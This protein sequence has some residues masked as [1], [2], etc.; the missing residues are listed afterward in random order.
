MLG[1]IN[2]AECICELIGC[3]RVNLPKW[4]KMACSHMDRSP[5]LRKSLFDPSFESTCIH[6]FPVLYEGLCLLSRTKMLM[7]G[8]REIRHF[9]FCTILSTVA[10]LDICASILTFELTNSTPVCLVSGHWPRHSKPFIPFP[11]LSPHD[12]TLSHICNLLLCSS[13]YMPRPL[14]KSQTL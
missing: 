5:A 6:F 14:P 13:L 8:P 7:A 12:P 11:A 10:M 4:R 1:F 9:W 2:S 3:T